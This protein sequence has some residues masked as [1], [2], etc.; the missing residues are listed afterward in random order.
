VTATL[1]GTEFTATTVNGSPVLTAVS[2]TTGLAANM[3]V[4][5]AGIRAGAQVVTIV[6]TTVTLDE[7]ALADGTAVP[8][9]T[10]R[11]V[12]NVDANPYR[13]AVIARS[14]STPDPAGTLA[15]AQSQKPL[16]MLLTGAY[17]STVPL[18]MEYT[19]PLS[20]ITATLATA[21]LADVTT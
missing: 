9:R 11:I 12:E 19:R 13:L 4:A 16:A 1:T 15:A 14:A 6:G 2:D 21:T 3:T 8:M 10:A 20:A 18:V 5:G 17:F 7:P